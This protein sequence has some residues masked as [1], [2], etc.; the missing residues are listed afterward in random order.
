MLHLLIE[1]KVLAQKTN[2]TESSP[3][4][5]QYQLK[6]TS[7]DDDLENEPDPIRPRMSLGIE[8][9]EGDSFHLPPILSIPLEDENHTLQSVEVPRRATSEQPFGRLSNGSFGSVLMTDRFA[10]LDD[11]SQGL[12]LEREE[13]ITW[14]PEEFGVYDEGL[15][16]QDAEMDD[17]SV[18]QSHV[19]LSL[20]DEYHSDQTPTEDLHRILAEQSTGRTSDIRNV[21]HP[22]DYDEATFMFAIPTNSIDPASSPQ[23]EAQAPAKKP[24]KSA[25][26]CDTVKRKG[27]KISTHGIPYPQFPTSVIKRLISR[28]GRG[29]GTSKTIISKE[30]IT[31]IEQASDL[32]FQQIGDDLASYSRHAHKKTIDEG[33][34][35]MLMRR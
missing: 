1:L 24:A 23:A 27:I 10:D 20:T 19:Y 22:N 11:L 31:A 28:F 9:D 7:A 4:P 6:G 12:A 26:S 30:A 32:F 17:E 29:C 16:Q 14:M 2:V 35:A 21:I 25:E 13:E 18:T 3:H 33:D 34:M 15:G 5:A 8:Y